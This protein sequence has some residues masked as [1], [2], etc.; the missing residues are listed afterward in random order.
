MTP[1][2][3]VHCAGE[4]QSRL[5][6]YRASRYPDGRK[7]LRSGSLALIDYGPSGDLDVDLRVALLALMSTVSMQTGEEGQK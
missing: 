2:R 3:G 5:R 6:P 1:S 4:G 7:F